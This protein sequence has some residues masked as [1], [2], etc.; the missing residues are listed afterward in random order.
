M[1]VGGYS[2]ILHGYN[3]TTG[4]LDLWVRPSSENYDK[5][6]KAFTI[7]KM[8]L[9]G[10]TRERFLSDKNEVFTYGRPPVSIDIMT[11]V[12]GLDFEETFRMATVHMVD[13]LQIKVI[14]FN[15]LIQAK[16]AAGRYKDLDDL[17]NLI[18]ALP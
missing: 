15:H 3:R 2:V 11:Q 8:P 1:L 6:I 10:M 12:K 18:P 5:L 13:K 17:E 7:F 9:F 4:Y 16:K 14:H